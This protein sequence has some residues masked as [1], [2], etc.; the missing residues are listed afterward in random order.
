MALC[1]ARAPLAMCAKP[2]EVICWSAACG[3][4]EDV[5]CWLRPEE[6]RDG[7]WRTVRFLG[8]GSAEGEG[9]AGGGCGCGVG[10]PAG[11]SLGE[12]IELMSMVQPKRAEAD[13][14]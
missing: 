12:S 13:A 7:I 11:E 2:G 14:G 3:C 10:V 1:I 5:I 6:V 8:E 9:R 4:G